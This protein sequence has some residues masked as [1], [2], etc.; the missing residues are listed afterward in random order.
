MSSN[1][2][3][4]V[5][6]DQQPIVRLGLN[7]ML[8]QAKIPVLGE[9]A[10]GIEAVAL[11]KKLKPSVVILNHP[12]PDLNGLNAA[13]D[14][15]QLR[16]KVLLFTSDSTEATLERAY[17]Y[18]VNGYILKSSPGFADIPKAVQQIFDGEVWYDAPVKE[19]YARFAHMPG[20]AAREP[21]PLTNAQQR[22]LQL[23]AEGRSSKEISSMLGI[24]T[25]TANKHRQAIAE[26]LGLHDTA[27]LVRYAIIN[28]V[29]QAE[30]V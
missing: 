20:Y 14:I 10:S 11:A 15:I 29:A 23:V 1:K 24:S 6:A 2:C 9:T 4:V 7:A 22:V 28:K 13:L 5:I 21:L 8:K 18:G 19:H 3:T 17:R 25:H 30:V 12:L 16:I 26:R 27:G